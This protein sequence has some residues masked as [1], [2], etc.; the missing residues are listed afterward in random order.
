MYCNALLHPS[1]IFSVVYYFR[2][3]HL[4]MNLLMTGRLEQLEKNFHHEPFLLFSA[5]VIKKWILRKL[6][7]RKEKYWACLYTCLRQSTLHKR[8][9]CF[10][11]PLLGRL[12]QKGFI[13]FS[14]KLEIF[15]AFIRCISDVFLI[16]L[17]NSMI[18]KRTMVFRIS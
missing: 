17:L 16:N 18:I 8:A 14:D 2:Y 10:F 12:M 7:N 11:Y 1:W 13:H 9:I 3:L 15:F 6:R 5:S 4:A